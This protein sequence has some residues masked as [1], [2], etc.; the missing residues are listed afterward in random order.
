M[1][2]FC[3]QHATSKEVAM[4]KMSF[5]SKAVAVTILI[6]L[7]LAAFPTTSAVAKGTNESL[8]KKWDQLVTNYDRQT[9]NHASVHRWVDHWSKTHKKA[10]ASEKAEIEK[11][12]AICNS[13]LMSA[14]A[15]VSKHA[16]F[17]ANGNVIER[18]SAIK[19]IKDLTYYLRQHAG[20]IKNL[21]EHLN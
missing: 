10:D 14:G 11:H 4:S 16:G 5:L 17:D 20:S 19:S 18:A 9:S 1:L 6:A 8:E 13:A 12:L 3:S 21:Q 2:L 7:V 15:I